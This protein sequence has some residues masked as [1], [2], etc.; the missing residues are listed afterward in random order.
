MHAWLIYHEHMRNYCFKKVN[1]H[2]M[3]CLVKDLDSFSMLYCGIYEGNA[4]IYR[5]Y[6]NDN[7]NRRNRFTAIQ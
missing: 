4:S 2:F 7:I 5:F 3:S 6:I 1:D